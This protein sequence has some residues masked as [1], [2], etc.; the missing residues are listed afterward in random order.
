MAGRNSQVSRIYML[1]TI[2]E[3]SRNGLTA[4]QLADRLHE[5]GF[6]VSKRTVYRDLEA[7]QAA[8]FPLIDGG[9]DFEHGT[10]WVLETTA[11]KVG[12]HFVLTSRELIAL[13]LA[14]RC[15]QPL[16]ETPFYQDLQSTF[17]K[18]EERISSQ[19][20]NF[21]DELQGEFQFEPGPQWGL[22][23]SPQVIDTLHACCSERHQLEVTYASANSGTT[24]RRRLGPHYLYLARGS[25][26]F[27]AEDLEDNTVKVFSVPRMSNPVMLD[28]TYEG[29]I[30]EPDEFFESAFGVYRAGDPV[31][32]KLTF[33]KVLGPYIKERRWH[34][35]Q[36]VV[37]RPDGSV[38][39]TLESGITPELVQWVQSFGPDVKV[40]EPNELIQALCERAKTMLDQYNNSKKAS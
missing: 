6:S 23:S 26:Y 18:I 30:I 35:S 9:T 40:L 38:E 1:L 22:G 14:K 12:Q 29:R 17:S 21:L 15:L 25:L 2:L 32:I 27:V 31:R 36:Q 7:L 20:Q 39:M 37:S 3:G 13:Y 33:S 24:R 10:K 34:T 28:A 11:T 16:Q 19:G 5:R 4:A 8:G